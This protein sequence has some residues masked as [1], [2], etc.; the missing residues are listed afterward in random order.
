LH[1]D[2]RKT[3]VVASTEFGSA[4]R[5][6]SFVI[7]IVLLPLICTGS[8]VLQLFVAKR[9]DTRERTIAVIDGTAALVPS[10]ETA[11]AAYNL[12]TVDSQGKSI[13]PRIKVVRVESKVR[14][15]IE[16]ALKLELSDRIKRGELDAFVVIPPDAIDVPSS[17]DG[18]APVLDFHSDNPNDDVLRNWLAASVN[19]EVR[20]R[21]F[22]SA[23]IDQSIA[24]R[25]LQPLS[26]ENLGLFDR[27]RSGG[28]AELAIKAAQKVDP[29][30]TVLVPAVL[31]V[32]MFLVIMTSSPQLVNSVLE[33][34]ISKISEVLLGSVTPFELL[35]GK[36]LGNAAVAVVLAV[37]Y[38]ACGYGVATYYGY[39]DVVTPSM[40]I[41]LVVY[42]LV[43]ILLYGSL[44]M[45][46]GAACNELKDAQTLM[47]PV[48]MVS[49]FP[50][51]VWVAVLRSPT[52]PLAVGLT[53][54]PPATPFL[55]LMR[56]A[57][58]PAP[59]YW[60]VALSLVL[61]TLTA[62]FCVW[63]S[64]KIFRTGLLMQGKS[65]TLREL[66]RW[67]VAK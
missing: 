26:L 60:H 14:E 27:D 29:V 28:G 13:R 2:S 24:D 4:I 44:F 67:V 41:A 59:P 19:G 23:G 42:L 49:M 30:R 36:L 21:R 15:Q 22:R 52:S 51:F 55:M 11:A 33:E 34:K 1:A 46:V 12:Q 43:A 47:M 50:V 64:A 35:M 48:M 37:F 10:L 57:L 39:G 3:W 7:G 25:A 56:L 65:P 16:P 9:V 45:A 5:T 62:L 32:A 63:A 58:R 61:A 17:K 54:F 6:R 31:M 53:L 18:Q 20:S 66:A 40:L 8:I 38:L